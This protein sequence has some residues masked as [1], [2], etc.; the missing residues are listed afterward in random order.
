MVFELPKRLCKIDLEP[1]K[2]YGYRIKVEGNC[3][4]LLDDVKENLG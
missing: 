1:D 3:S 4:K 2:K